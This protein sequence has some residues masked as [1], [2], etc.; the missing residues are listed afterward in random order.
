MEKYKCLIPKEPYILHGGDYNPDQWLDCSEILEQDMKMMKES[1]CNTVSLGIFAW[2]ALEPEE[3]VFTFEWLDRIMDMLTENGIYAFLATPSGARPAWMSKKYPEV[4]RVERNRVKNLYGGRHNHCWTSPVYREKVRIINTKLAQRYKDHPALAGWHISNE[5]GGECHCPLCQEKFRE[6]LKEKYGTL[7]NLNHQWW[8][9]F[10]SHRYTDWEQ[11]ESPAPHGEMQLHGLDLDWHRFTTDR[12][13]DFIKWESKP[14]IKYSPNIPRA[15]NMMGTYNGL[16]YWKVAKAVD[17]V[18]W[19]SYPDWHKPGGNMETA[20]TAAFNHDV[21]RSLKGDQPFIMMESTPSITNW[22]RVNK[23]KRPGMHKLASI[24]A[25]AHGADGVLYFQWRKS[26]G[27]S[28]KFHGAVVDHVG[29]TNTRVFKD[30]AE[31]GE[32]LKKLAPVA[33]SLAEAET[34]VIF[35]WDNRWAL[36]TMMGLR[37]DREEYEE[38]CKSHYRPFWEMGIPVDVIES[39]QDFS[40]YKLLI[41]PMLYMTKPGVAERIDEFVKAGGTFVAT[42]WSGIVNENDLVHLGGFPGPL[43]KTLGIWSEEIDTLYDEDS[44]RAVID[45]GT[46]KGEYPIQM[47]CDLI[48]AETAQV[49]GVYGEDFYKGMPALTVNKAG[50]GEAYY[51]AFRDDGS[52]VKD[53]YAVLAE[54]IGLHKAV[55]KPVEGVTATERHNADETYLF[56]QNWN[57]SEAE[58]EVGEGYV[59]CLTDLPSEPVI[60]LE[61]YGVKILRRSK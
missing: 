51:I 23:L 7:D 40:K 61:R 43:R 12:C 32:I 5:Y 26:R 29:T 3:G 17:F 16:D 54:K 39:Q 59:D 18:S 35:D 11:I 22:H 56:V 27:G 60:K 30:V 19:D 58:A 31:L 46:L 48:H 1:G 2:T 28:E 45:A 44:N 42:Y 14:L 52:F 20:C 53:F 24:Q 38:I 9:S 8:T 37:N 15:V 47:Y 50:K 55:K 36:Q 6:W 25:V 41:A 10:W 33:G 34:A 21:I 49:L 13:I 4:L 57:E